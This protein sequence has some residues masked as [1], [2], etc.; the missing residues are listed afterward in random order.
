MV[1]FIHTADWQ[2]GMKAAHVGRAAERVRAERMDAARRVV[3]TARQQHAEFII[4]A[5]DTFEDN[6]VDRVLVQRVADILGSSDQPVFI[7]PGNH[8]P[9]TPG[10]V[11]EHPAWKS[12]GNLHLLR[13]SA[14]LE[15]DQVVLY[16]AP[17]R[18]KHSLK[19][20]TRW[21]DA[22]D[23][24]KIAIG[25]AHGTVEGVSQSE[26]DYPIARDAVHRSGL[27]YLALGHWHS[28]G[29]FEDVDGTPRMAYSGT[30]ETTKFGERDSGNALLVE[31][32][33]RGCSPQL[34][35]LPTGGLT[36]ET[37]DEEIRDEGDLPRFRETI[38][39][40]RG[41]EH[42]LLDVRLRGLL[43]QGSQAELLRIDELVRARFLY[44]RID[45][46]GL[47]LPPDDDSWLAEIPIGTLRDVAQQLHAISQ[48]QAGI[49]RPDYATPEVAT[50]AMLELYRIIRE[51]NP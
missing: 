39:T 36:W 46:S 22:R 24:Q 18:E 8:D 12:H 45:H 42:T 9:L 41:A 40:R 50:R 49:E 33:G 43:H 34:T 27:D 51:V 38:E 11:W 28:F 48:D 29:T 4:V 31:I 13:E 7:I 17:L 14:L 2:I 30:H 23:S 25:I 19:D 37:I 47:L 5:G 26:L 10:S 20:P 32:A 44:A 15:L 6:A 3:D 21:M 16:P 35:S 1:R